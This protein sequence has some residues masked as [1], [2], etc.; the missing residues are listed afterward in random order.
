MLGAT[1]VPFIATFQPTT[2]STD[3][4]TPLASGMTA[5]LSA[6]DVEAAFDALVRVEHPGDNS[7]D[8]I[9]CGSCHLATASELLIAKPKFGLDDRTSPLAFQPDGIHVLAS[10][11]TPTFDTTSSAR[12]NMHAFSYVGRGASINQRVVNESAAVVE[13]LNQLVE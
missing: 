10:D 6:A 11:M 12:V 3:N 2:I 1:L 13:Y 5:D 4:L 7:P 8:T 9:D